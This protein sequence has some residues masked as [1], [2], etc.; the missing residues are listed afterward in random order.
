MAKKVNLKTYM[1]ISV[2]LLTAFS[3][4]LLA[5]TYSGGAGEPNDPYQISSANDMNEI[6]THPEDWNDCFVLT[7]DIN[8]AAY[9][10]QNGNAVLT[11]IAS[12]VEN[13]LAANITGKN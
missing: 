12:Q 6:G 4:N 1:L 11:I 3:G 9:N 7:T 13:R 10:G 5:S 2:F 8:L